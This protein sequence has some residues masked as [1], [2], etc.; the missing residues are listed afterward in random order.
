MRGSLEFAE[1]SVAAKR[2]GK[3]G[4]GRESIYS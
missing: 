4:D 2:Q 3:L 1:Q